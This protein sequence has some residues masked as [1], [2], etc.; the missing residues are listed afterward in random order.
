[1]R[2]PAGHR[3]CTSRVMPVHFCTEARPSRQHT[4]ATEAPIQFNFPRRHGGCPV[5][6]GLAQLFRIYNPSSIYRRDLL[7]LNI[8]K[9]YSFILIELM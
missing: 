8:E 5:F 2:R 4:T 9:R 6:A 3:F 7:L 1:M